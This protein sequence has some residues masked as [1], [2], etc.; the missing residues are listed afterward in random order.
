MDKEGLRGLLDDLLDYWLCTRKSLGAEQRGTWSE[1]LGLPPTPVALALKV[2]EARRLLGRLS[3]AE[4]E[5]I[6]SF[7]CFMEW[8]C[9]RAQSG[10]EVCARLGALAAPAALRREGQPGGNWQSPVKYC[11][12]ALRKMRGE[13]L[14]D[15]LGEV[16]GPPEGGCPEVG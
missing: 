3:E 15:E 6:P 12:N 2:R 5:P 14:R 10:S 9:A 1:L 13:P 7:Y 8:V 11:L 4:P 16:R